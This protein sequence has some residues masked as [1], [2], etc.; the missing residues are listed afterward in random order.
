M[1]F[2]STAGTGRLTRIASQFRMM[3]GGKSICVLSLLFFGTVGYA[4]ND[5]CTGIVDSIGDGYCDQMNNNELCGYDEGINKSL[6][7]AVLLF[8]VKTQDW[9]VYTRS[10]TPSY[11]L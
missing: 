7:P 1:C 8:S 2:V 10:N 9:A 4:Q 11:N 5:N 3:V 6:F